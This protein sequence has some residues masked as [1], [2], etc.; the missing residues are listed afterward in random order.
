[1]CKSRRSGFQKGTTVYKCSDCGHRTRT[2]GHETDGSMCA[3]C[4]E[5]SL[6]ENS[7]SDWHKDT[8]EGKYAREQYKIIA[9]DH[10]HKNVDTSWIEEMDSK[11]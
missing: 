11:R 9:K 5:L 7:I 1:M 6:L 3:W 2:T 10:P 8:E 4:N